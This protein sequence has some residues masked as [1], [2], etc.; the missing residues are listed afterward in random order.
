MPTVARVL[1]R[2]IL[3]AEPVGGADAHALH[4]AVG[5]DRQRLAVLHR[6]QQHQPDIAAVRRGRHLFAPH[7]VAA[8]W[9]R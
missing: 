9:A 7:V 6:E 2:E 1:A 3:D 5:Q 4:D 8:S